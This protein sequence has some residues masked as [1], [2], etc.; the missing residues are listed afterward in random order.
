LT[1]LKKPD[2]PV[3]GSGYSGFG[4]F[5]AN[6]KDITRRNLEFKS[7][8]RHAKG[9]KNIKEPK[10]RRLEPKAK[11]AKNWVF[12]FWILDDP[13]FPEKIEVK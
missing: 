6:S 3:P 10:Q 9:G 4:S 13:V 5:R 11:V 12:R 2:N 8:L 1:R 7:V